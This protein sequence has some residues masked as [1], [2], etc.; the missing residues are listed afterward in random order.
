M[1]QHEVLSNVT[2][3]LPDLHCGACLDGNL[4]ETPQDCTFREE[5]EILVHSCR[6]AKAN[7]SLPPSLGGPRQPR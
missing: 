5:A 7:G 3:D 6:M 2:F 4:P 1:T